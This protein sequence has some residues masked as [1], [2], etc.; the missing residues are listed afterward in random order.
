MRRGE[1]ERYSKGLETI[2]SHLEITA[3]RLRDGS[4]HDA[5]FEEKELLSRGLCVRDYFKDSN[6]RKYCCK[7]L[8]ILSEATQ[9][10]FIFNCKVL[11][12][13]KDNIVDTSPVEH[14]SPS[15]EGIFSISLLVNI[16]NNGQ[17]LL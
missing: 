17:Y 12:V 2:R 7:T 8:L 5:Q 13:W 15:C 14:K 6:K 3:K 9:N 1:G 16:E 4:D 10:V 11:G